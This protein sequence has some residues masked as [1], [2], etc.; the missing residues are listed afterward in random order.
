MAAFGLNLGKQLL[1]MAAKGAKT[2]G[3]KAGKKGTATR[4]SIEG[5]LTKSSQ[6]MLAQPGRIGWGLPVIGGTMLGS[7]GIN[8]MGGAAG[9]PD[10]PSMDYPEAVRDQRGF[11]QDPESETGWSY[12]QGRGVAKEGSDK[13][14]MGTGKIVQNVKGDAPMDGSPMHAQHKVFRAGD[15]GEL[16]GRMTY[17][18][19]L[20]PNEMWKM[21]YPDAVGAPS[22]KENLAGT[23][24]SAGSAAD[25]EIGP[26]QLAMIG[27]AAK[28]TGRTAWDWSG[29]PG[30]YRA[31]P[32]GPET[33][34]WE[35]YATLPSWFVGGPVLKGAGKGAWALGKKM[36]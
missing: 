3:P 16:A 9:A 5:P 29:I 33:E 2:A 4:T 21:Q 6:E 35:D 26:E 10:V 31:I 18:S 13:P 19:R 17:G 12:S 30:A 1:K 14:G 11:F 28:A 15:K 34:G 36:F 24:T 32:G 20:G 27:N 22:A 25:A 8:A 7:A 23:M